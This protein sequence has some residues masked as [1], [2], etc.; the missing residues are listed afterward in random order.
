LV[1]ISWAILCVAALSACIQRQTL[2][3][4]PPQPQVAAPSAPIQPVTRGPLLPPG[5]KVRVALLLPLTGSSNV[6]GQAMLD[7]AAMALYDLGS[8][9]IQLMPHDT[10]GA[11]QGAESAA[12]A[13]VADQARL[14]IGPLLAAEVEAVKPIARR[15]NIPILAFSTVTGLAG[16][17]TYLMGFLP[18]T[19]IARIV[20]F[21]HAKGANKFAIFAPRSAYGDVALK[22]MREAVAANQSTL[23]L[24]DTFDPA[25]TNLDAAVRS[26]TTQSQDYDAILLPEGGSQLRQ[27]AALLNQYGVK[28]DKVRYLGT[29]LWDD[30]SLGSETS[31]V[32]GWYA[33]PQP[34]ARADFER[35][36]RAA[37]GHAPPRLATLAYDASA[38]AAVLARTPGGATYSAAALTNPNG[39]VGL[40]GVFRLR[41]N[42]LIERA[43][44]ILEVH[45]DGPRIV[46]PAPQSF[47]AVGG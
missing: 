11:P 40:D 32:N 7:A 18:Q 35:R 5:A 20:S 15:A 6:L 28:P 14:V 39:F 37:E 33:G 47:V 21:A 8:D 16:D 42:G 29:G 45:P 9:Q 23:T 36:F 38:L 17:G 22:A 26:F 2:Q 4:Q 41:D 13:A 46:D 34:G 31:L 25:A 24:A 43:L 12:R 30:P 27:L 44:A 19:E 10:G 1:A 3:N